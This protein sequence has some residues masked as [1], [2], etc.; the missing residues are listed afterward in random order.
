MIC[1]FYL[2]CQ[3]LSRELPQWETSLSSYQWSLGNSWRIQI[4]YD[5]FLSAFLEYLQLVSSNLLKFK[6]KIVA[7]PIKAMFCKNLSHL[8]SLF[9][10]CVPLLSITTI[11]IITSPM[12]CSWPLFLSLFSAQSFSSENYAI[13]QSLSNRRNMLPFSG[14]DMTFSF[15]FWAKTLEVVLVWRALNQY[16]QNFLGLRLD[17]DVPPRYH[18]QGPKLLDY[19]SDPQ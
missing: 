11:I 8:E 14:S 2:K 3:H 19:F 13:A 15:I 9:V 16:P 7:R 12:L 18:R 5:D 10:V 17:R 6:S 1:S 4:R